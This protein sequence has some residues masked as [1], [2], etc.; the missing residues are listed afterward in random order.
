MDVPLHDSL[1]GQVALVTGASRG[2][3][4]AIADELDALGATVYGGARNPDDVSDAHRALRLDV[5]DEAD[6][7]NAVDHLRYEAERLDVLVN[8][9]GVGGPA[10]PVGESTT[11]GVDRVLDVNLRGPIL[12]A[13]HCLDL[14]L[15]RDGGR[16]VNVSSTGGQLSGDADRWRGVYS[17]S[18]SGLNGLTKQLHGA[19]HDDGLVAN[20]ASPGWVQTDLGGD[21]APRTPEEG[22]DTPAWLARFAPDA[23]AGKFWEDREVIDW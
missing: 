17:L 4:A 15:E 13:N 23:P 22:A 3:G 6:I 11:G 12:L 2:I 7:G 21:D 16:V 20:S 1:D 9:A 8:N 19:Y 10:G 18:K 5:T 14:L